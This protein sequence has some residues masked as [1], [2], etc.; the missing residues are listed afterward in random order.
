MQQNSPLIV[1]I[2]TALLA[3]LSWL[4]QQRTKRHQSHS[5]DEFRALDSAFNDQLVTRIDG[6]EYRIERIETVMLNQVVSD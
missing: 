1:P 5:T 6:L 4:V 2:V 3:V